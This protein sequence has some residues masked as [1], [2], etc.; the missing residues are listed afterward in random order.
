MNTRNKLA[1][2]LLNTGLL[3]TTTVTLAQI[4]G[5]GRMGGNQPAFADFDQD[6]NGI[7][8]E[9]EFI[10]ARGERIRRRAEQGR[11]MRR[12]E[13]IMEFSAIDRDGNGRVTADEFS[14]AMQQHRQK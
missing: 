9:S 11:R 2:A 7:L 10:E 8:T 14:A 1:K 12:L 4:P 13:N 3:L 5:Q 6:G